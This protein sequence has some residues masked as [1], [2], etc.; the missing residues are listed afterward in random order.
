MNGFYN[1]IKTT[2]L[3][4]VC[5]LFPFF[6]KAQTELITNGDFSQPNGWFANGDFYYNTAFN[7]CFDYGYAY[8]SGASGQWGNNLSGTLYQNVFIPLNTQSA[9]LS[10]DYC[11]SSQETSLTITN[12][13]CFIGVFDQS[14]NLIVSLVTMSNIE[15]NTGV[16]NYPPVAIPSSLFGQTIQVRFTSFTNSTLP[17]TFRIDNVSL[18]AYSPSNCVTWQNGTPNIDVKNAMDELCAEGIISNQQDNSTL[19]NPIK[20]FEVARYLKQA[21]LGNDS[22]TLSFLD[23]FPNVFPDI[24]TYPSIDTQRSLKLMLYLEYPS[25]FGTGL[26]DI[27][28]FSREYNYSNLS[29]VIISKSD[30][31]KAMLETWNIKPWMLN[32]NPALVSNSPNICDMK[33]SNKNLG[34]VEKANQLGLLSG[35]IGTTCSS[36]NN[37]NFGIDNSITYSEF[38]RILARLIRQPI[39]TLHYSDFFIPNLF[40]LNNQNSNVDVEKGVF[41]EY[42]D[43]SFTIPGGGLPLN[44][45]HSYH[46]NFTEVPLKN[47]NNNIENEVLPSKLEPLGGGWTHTYSSF[48]KTYSASVPGKKRLLIYWSDGTIDSY[49]VTDSKYETKGITDKLIINNYSSDIPSDITIQK[50][51]IKYHFELVDD[52]RFYTLNLESI[53]DAF[54]NT[55]KLEYENGSLISGFTPK[56]LKRVTDSY[57]NRSLLFAYQSGSN[58]LQSITDPLNRSITFY[59]NKYTHSLD[60]FADAKNQITRYYYDEQ[61]GTYAYRTNLLNQIQR[62]KGNF[63]NNLYYSRKLKQ[64]KTNS[65]TIQV[66]AVPN[67]NQAWTQQQSQVTTTQNSQTLSTNYTFDGLGNTINTSTSTESIQREYDSEN[68]ILSERDKDRGFI[69]KYSYDANGYLNRQVTIDSFY[70]DSI[71]YDYTNNAFGEVIQIIDNNDPSFSYRTTYIERTSQGSPSAVYENYNTGG[72]IRHGYGYNSNGLVTDYYSPTRLH[73]SFEYNSFGNVNKV[74][75]FPISGTQP[76]IA[77][78]YGYDAVSRLTS[79]INKNNVVNTFSYDN[80]DNL[81]TSVEDQGGLNLTTV[82]SYDKNDN[83]I[84]ILSPKGHTTILVYDTYTDD[85]IEENDGT[86]KKNWTY[87]EDGT[88]KTFSNKNSQVFNY[89]YF[90]AAKP[91]LKG[92]FFSDGSRFLSYWESTRELYK[93]NNSSGKSNLFWYDSRNRG[94]WSKPPLVSTE[95]FFTGS[96]PDNVA[97]GYDRLGRPEYVAY[98]TF[99]STDF[100]IGYYYDLVTKKL[101]LVQDRNT[102]KTYAKYTYD[103]DSKPLTEI[104]GNGDTTFYHYDGLNRLD[105]IWATNKRG[106]L[107]YSIGASLDNEGKHTRENLRLF[108]QGQEV[109]TLPPLVSQRPTNYTYELRNRI[110]SNGFTNFIHDGAGNLTNIQRTGA[111]YT[112]SNY[113]QLTGIQSSSGNTVYEYDPLGNRRRYNDTY[114][115]L[116]QQNSNGNILM[117]AKQN[118]IPISAYIWGNGLIARVDP[119]NDSTFYYH[120]DFRGSIIAITN[121]N[122][123][124]VQYYK[125]EPFGNIYDKQGTITWNNPYTYV[126]KHGVQADSNGLYYMKARYYNSGMGRFINEDP[127]W[128]TNLYPYADNDP[129][130]KIDPDGK[131]SE[132]IVARYLKSSGINN[133][134]WFRFGTNNKGMYRFAWGSNPNYKHFE[135]VPESLVGINQALR[136]FLGGHLY[137]YQIEFLVNRLVPFLIIP[138][139]NL[140]LFLIK[141]GSYKPI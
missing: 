24:E 139:D 4:L 69:T 134:N 66:D 83:N 68:R 75:V 122:G 72:Q 62:P 10:F 3:L 96:T 54:N 5:F 35:I 61:I 57:S 116:D 33:V 30:A 102:S 120:Y 110:T 121:E 55:L 133:N 87:N 93:I 77:D 73:T 28:P 49:S 18:V 2:L 104:Y 53:T 23:N 84:S 89:T 16:R 137:I 105:S 34:W 130:N 19:N 136:K 100:N 44:F 25:L 43:N 76:Y 129:V 79:H 78:A 118:T 132:D 39:P 14:N 111:T 74:K 140:N 108:Y 65:Y 22:N 131:I 6:G 107:L 26:D 86:N 8:S 94:K 50:G 81:L 70:N 106:Q 12:D 125:Y 64:T 52:F 13:K 88:L 109:T 42:S 138:K 124:I 60:S 115:V 67:Y 127:V 71:K 123:D 80:N 38:Y 17:T 103:I 119:T 126:G 58:Y 141:G 117:E 95:G 46:S 31:I 41:N 37:I 112:W 91:K 21:L 63:V 1:S 48:I 128:H 11:I 32:Y 20:K 51:R 47:F 98:P 9:Y 90:D 15:G 99:G 85:L 114:Y 36:P 97:Y 7:N 113:N 45:Q 29:D 27:A 92:M 59:A 101:N 40:Y 82:N 135:K 56:R